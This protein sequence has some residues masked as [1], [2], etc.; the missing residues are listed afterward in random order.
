MR[1]EEIARVLDEKLLELW[2]DSSLSFRE[3][4]EEMGM[5]LEELRAAVRRLGLKNRYYSEDAE[6][7]PEQ[8]RAWDERIARRKAEVQGWWTPS[9]EWQHR[10]TKGPMR[11][12]VPRVQY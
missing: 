12:E 7:T 8:E 2:N 1:A 5:D 6:M 4:R 3:I 9:E 10:V 11:Y